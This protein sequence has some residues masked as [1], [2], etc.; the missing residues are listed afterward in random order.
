MTF[1]RLCSDLTRTLGSRN[2]FRGSYK[3][4]AAF[5]DK[6][7]RIV[8]A[9]FTLHFGRAKLSQCVL[10]S[11]KRNQGREERQAWKEFLHSKPGPDVWALGSK[12]RLDI[13]V[14]HPVRGSIGIEVKWLSSRGHAAKLTQGLGQVALALAN[15]QRTLLL[16]HCGSVSNKKRRDLRSIAR[17]I[18]RATATQMVIVP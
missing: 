17:R 5:E 13:V 10:T 6:V 7:W 14:K 15:R 2:R 11:H 3:S 4:E 16:I 8:R 18:C 1:S 12:N 9:R